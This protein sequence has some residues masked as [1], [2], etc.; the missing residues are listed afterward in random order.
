MHRPRGARSPTRA[1]C[2]LC[3]QFPA[4][5]NPCPGL[6]LPSRAEMKGIPKFKAGFCQRRF[7]FFFF[8]LINMNES[9]SSGHCRISG[10][11]TQFGRSMEGSEHLE[12]NFGRLCWKFGM[13]LVGMGLPGLSHIPPLVLS[14]ISLPQSQQELSDLKLGI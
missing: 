1:G 7:F 11:V 4:F 6:F 13:L 12:L 14:Q 5:H 3:P 10:N 8:S 9:L 2:S